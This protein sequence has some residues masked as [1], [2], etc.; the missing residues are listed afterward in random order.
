[1]I[2]LRIVAS[3][4][5]LAV[6]GLVGVSVMAHVAPGWMGMVPSPTALRTYFEAAGAPMPHLG[7]MPVGERTMA[8][9][10]TG[11]QG[12]PPV[13][14]IH[15]SP[16]DWTAWK[17]FLAHEDLRDLRLIAVDRPGYGGSGRGDPLPSI[18]GQAAQVAAVIRE[19]TPG[20]S[21]VVVGHSLG[22][23]IAGQL[24]MDAPELVRGLVLVAPSV[25]PSLEETKWI[26]VPA[27]WPV[28][29]SV[30]PPE[31]DV[32]NREILPLKGQLRAMASGWAD[33][34]LDVV[35]IQ[36]LAD[37]LVP[38]GNAG[39]LEQRLKR[40]TVRRVPGL[41]HFVPWERPDLIRDAIRGLIEESNP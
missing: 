1:V 17:G 27:Q 38:P 36:G 26:Q 10:T 18:Q 15:G 25:D 14:F 3:L 12:A 33:L 40:G 16:G 34:E 39:F 28:I 21:A 13:V 29:R 8:Y 23:P 11:P 30:I 24:A 6:L 35:V 4:V 32:C 41:N 7:L 37:R 9:A 31:L 2:W 20:R 5:G 22:G 19:V